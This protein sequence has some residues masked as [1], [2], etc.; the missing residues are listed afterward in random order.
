MPN[1][2]HILRIRVEVEHRVQKEVH[3][4]FNSNQSLEDLAK[5]L[6]SLGLMIEDSSCFKGGCCE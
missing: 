1:G 3:M 5:K 2:D 4:R 6:I